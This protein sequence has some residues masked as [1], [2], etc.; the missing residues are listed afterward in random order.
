MKVRC[1]VCNKEI[2]ISPSRFEKSTTKEFCC[3][4]ECDIKNRISKN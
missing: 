1:I 2:D 3:S 4:K